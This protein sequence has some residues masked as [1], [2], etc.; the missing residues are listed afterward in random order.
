MKRAALVI[1][2]STVIVAGG[3]TASNMGFKVRYQLV[4]S[5]QPSLSGTNFIG[6]PYVP[7]PSLKTARDLF[8]DIG[9][10]H[11]QIISQYIRNESSSQL[12]EFYTFGGGTIPPNG[13]DLVPGEALIVK[14]GSQKLYGLV[15]SH[16]ST[17]EIEL[18]G[19][20]SP[21]SHDGSNFVAVPYHTTART[22]RDLFLEIGGS[23]QIINKHRPID[24]QFEFYAFGGGSVPPNGWDLVPGDGYLIKIGSDQTWHPSHY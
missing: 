2:V 22:A 19:S 10:D 4:G 21:N 15:G 11:V 16:D 9:V 6:L 3:I 13:W 20:A 24:D 23:I 5:P 18:I 7:K 17:Y 1:F 8:L 14:V 12:F